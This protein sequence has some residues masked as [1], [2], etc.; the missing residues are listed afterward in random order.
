MLRH[1][2]RSTS[3]CDGAL[4]LLYSGFSR[5]AKGFLPMQDCRRRSCSDCCS[6][7]LCLS[8]AYPKRPLGTTFFQGTTRHALSYPL[9]ILLS[10][11]SYFAERPF[12]RVQSTTFSRQSTLMIRTR[13]SYVPNDPCAH[14]NRRSAIFQT[15]MTILTRRR[16]CYIR[17][18]VNTASSQPCVHLCPMRRA[19][20]N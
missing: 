12:A 14:C 20:T 1:L 9:R 8:L 15:W 18:S 19:V 5:S 11:D 4:R 13:R 6:S 17:A 7:A 3:V 2:R 16:G 10:E